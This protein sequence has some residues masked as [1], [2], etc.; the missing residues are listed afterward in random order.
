MRIAYTT[1]YDATTTATGFTSYNGV[2]YHMAKAL[3]RAGLDLDY[4]GPLKEPFAC[5]FYPKQI[6]A[7]RY[8]H[9]VYNRHREVMACKSYSR[10]I[11]RA[12]RRGDYDVI[13]SGLSVGSQPVAYLK[14][15]KP[16]A[17]WTDSTLA[18]AVDFYPDMNRQGAIWSNLQAGLRN[19]RAAVNRASLLIYS[20]EWARR[21]AIQQYNLDPAKVKVVP[22]GANADEEP[23]R[24]FV[25]RAIEKRPADVCRLLFVGMDWFRKGGDEALAAAAYLKDRGIPVELTL[26]GSAPADTSQLPEYVKPMG[27]ITR[28]TPEGAAKLAELFSRSHFLILASKADAFGQVLVEANSF[29]VPCASSDVGGIPSIMRN[30]RNGQM[31]PAGSDGKR[32]GEWIAGVFANPARYR[33]MA[34]SSYE[35]YRSRLNWSSA[36]V[37]V[38]N[39]LGELLPDHAPGTPAPQLHAV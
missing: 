17:I 20:S 35:E 30:D 28:R 38:A 34:L 2:G 37:Q 12:V 25:E 6:L 10:Q 32:Y 1:I 8:L 4:I 14:T 15:D 9:K 31:F 24:A 22:L 27:L 11:G 39:L 19:E 29:G 13:F 18:S 21:E 26:V 36:G 5:L 3:S 16:I 33:A 7:Q 23:D